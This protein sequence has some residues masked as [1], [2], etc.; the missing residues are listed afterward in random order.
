MTIE[1]LGEGV[2]KQGSSVNSSKISPVLEKFKTTFCDDKMYK[3]KISSRDCLRL[4]NLEAL[5]KW[6]EES[7]DHCSLDC[8]KKSP[9]GCNRNLCLQTCDNDSRIRDMSAN[10]FKH[11]PELEA[12]E[13]RSPEDQKKSLDANLKNFM[14][15]FCKDFRNYKGKNIYE[16]AFPDK[17]PNYEGKFK[18]KQ[19]KVLN[20]DHLCRSSKS[21]ED[22]TK[23]I[24]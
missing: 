22:L 1:C 23:K 6:S 14:D 8:E 21:V 10:S 24:Y 18:Y 17:F 12:L 9:E 13:S 5:L 19:S 7:T 11:T 4:P 20:D 15:W 2:M 3:T 16:K